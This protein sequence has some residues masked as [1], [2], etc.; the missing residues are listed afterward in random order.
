[1]L[2]RPCEGSSQVNGCN[3]MPRWWAAVSV[4]GA[5]LASCA[6]VSFGES[7]FFYPDVQQQSAGYVVLGWFVITGTPSASAR[8]AG[9]QP[10]EG[11]S[12]NADGEP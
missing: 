3:L 10:P 9:A 12:R 11:T 4:G 7:G 1:M 2:A 6:A 8:S 5:V